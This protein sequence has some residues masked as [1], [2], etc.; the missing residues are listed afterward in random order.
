MGEL[1]DD[2]LANA[3]GGSIFSWCRYHCSK[4]DVCQKV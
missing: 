1:S 4:P 3:A 2:E